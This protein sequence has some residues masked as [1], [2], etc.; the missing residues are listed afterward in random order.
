M[1]GEMRFPERLTRPRSP[2]LSSRT[3]NE[4]RPR[5]GRRPVCEAASEPHLPYAPAAPWV[6][7]QTRL[8]RALTDGP[9]AGVGSTGRVACSTARVTRSAW[10]VRTR[11]SRRKP[12]RYCEP[13][14]RRD[15]VSGAPDEAALATPVVAHAE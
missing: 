10:R 5:V 2:R 15:A 14:D 7:V 3:R 9:P 6:A 1:T 4:P 13:D 12:C 11:Q 8:L